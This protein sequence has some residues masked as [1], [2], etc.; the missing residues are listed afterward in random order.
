MDR[1][2]H[3]FGTSASGV[4]TRLVGSA[5]N[6]KRLAVDM[7]ATANRARDT[8]G[9]AAQGSAASARDLSTVAAAAEQIAGSIARLARDVERSTQAVA[10]TVTRAGETDTKVQDM[11]AAAD[12]VSKIVHLI[13][14]IAAQTNL[15]ALNATIEAARAGEAG[16]GFAVVAGEVK[17]LAAQTARA[18]EEIGQEI[19][20]I[21]QTTQQAVGAV[22][23]VGEAIGEVSAVAKSI[24]AAIDQQASSTREIAG[25]VGRVSAATD[26]LSQAVD[27]VFTL[28]GEAEGASRS[29]LETAGE[30]GSVAEDLR[31]ELDGF[32]AS[33]AHSASEN[34]RAHER[35]AG[36]GATAT[37]KRPGGAPREARIIDISLGGVALESDADGP[38]GAEIIVTLPPAGAPVSGRI[39]GWRDGALTLSLGRDDAT[40]AVVESAMIDIA[41]RSARAA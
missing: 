19:E 6:M 32:L 31:H 25:S 8:S 27:V 10:R 39:V 33:I 38:A 17:A 40:T 7:A 5:E 23:A 2:T 15:L 14:S 3:A 28:S 24:E 34:R 12:R 30:V 29:V 35:I 22:R 37:I 16:R 13:S 20:A 1:Q 21:G 9:R 36:N 26:Q 18:T 4:M 11:A 41:R